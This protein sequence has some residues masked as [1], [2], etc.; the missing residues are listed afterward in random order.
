MINKYFILVYNRLIRMFKC[1]LHFWN[2]VA[3]QH[4]QGSLCLQMCP[5]STLFSC[6]NRRFYVSIVVS[7]FLLSFP[8]LFLVYLPRC[9]NFV[10]GFFYAMIQI[11][12][13]VVLMMYGLTF[14]NQV[15][16]FPVSF[17]RFLCLGKI[18]LYVSK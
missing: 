14:L 8:V 15:W 10:V 13:L 3:F 17:F 16:V 9:F 2:S 5:A 12:T 7:L 1:F 18:P 11:F 4:P 6:F